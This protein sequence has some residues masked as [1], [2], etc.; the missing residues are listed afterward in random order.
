[1]YDVEIIMK[2]RPGQLALMGET[3]G[4]AGIS[5]EGGGMFLV[6]G[7]GV[8]HFLFDDG[9]V[10]QVA[11]EAAGMR[12]TACREVLTVRLKQDEPGQL[13]KLTRAMADAGVNIEI[14]Y[15]D[16]DHQLILVVDNVDAGRRVADGWSA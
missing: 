7:D 16:H 11:L 9:P 3:L 10:A 13:G 5:V 6:A 8:A 1:M 2:N 14:L 15:S 12:V 4:E